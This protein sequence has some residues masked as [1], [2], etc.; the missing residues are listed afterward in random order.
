MGSVSPFVTSQPITV[1]E[2]PEQ[3]GGGKNT[4]GMITGIMSPILQMASMI[5]GPQQPFVAGAAGL[6]KAAHGV[7][8][9]NPNAIASGASQAIGAAGIDDMLTKKS[10]KDSGLVD[11]NLQK[12][13]YLEMLM[14][15][16]YTSLMPP[17]PQL[18]NQYPFQQPN[19]PLSQ[20]G[21][22]I[23]KTIR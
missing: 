18:P 1:Q 13:P 5:P 11:P 20:Y 4:G 21:F 23:T 14:Q 17:S 10:D 7:M 15:Q 3:Q 8:T 12:N 6:S 9:N 2:E 16:P 22:G 19:D